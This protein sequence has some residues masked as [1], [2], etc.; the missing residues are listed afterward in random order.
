MNTP[1]RITFRH[2]PASAALETKIRE[3]FGKLT[4]LY[5]EVLDCDAT[6]D[7]IDRHQHQGRHFRIALGVR[8]RGEELIANTNH[9]DAYIALRGA[10][11]AV[12]RQLDK[13]VGKR[14]FDATLAIDDDTLDSPGAEINTSAAETLLVMEEDEAVALLSGAALRP[15]PE[16]VIAAVEKY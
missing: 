9:E 2:M 3:K 15:D 14:R 10:V 13:A 16:R 11:A 7:Q 5:P 12:R 4:R 8:I 1:L 6:V